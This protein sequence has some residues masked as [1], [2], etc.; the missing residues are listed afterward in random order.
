MNE[1]TTTSQFS[2]WVIST[3]FFMLF[4]IPPSSYVHEDFTLVGK[5]NFTKRD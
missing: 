2:D 3:F 5:K 1:R 4:Y